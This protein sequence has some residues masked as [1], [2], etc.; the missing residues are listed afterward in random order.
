MGMNRDMDDV[1]LEV[2]ENGQGMTAQP[3]LGVGQSLIRDIAAAIAAATPDDVL[4]NA[5]PTL[6]ALLD[7]VIQ[8]H[9]DELARLL[10]VGGE[11]FG[12]DLVRGG[13]LAAAFRTYSAL[14]SQF[15]LLRLPVLHLPLEDLFAHVGV[16]AAVLELA[17]ACDLEPEFTLSCLELLGAPLAGLVTGMCEEAFWSSFGLDPAELD[18]ELVGL[19]RRLLTLV[20]HLT[21][22]EAAARA[23]WLLVNG[24]LFDKVGVFFRYF[25]RLAWFLRSGPKDLSYRQRLKTIITSQ[26]GNPDY[27][28]RIRAFEALAVLTGQKHRFRGQRRVNLRNQLHD[29][30]L[31]AT[32]VVPLGLFTWS[33]LIPLTVWAV[34]MALDVAVDYVPSLAANEVLGR[35]FFGGLL[36]A[37]VA[38][39]IGLVVGKVVGDPVS[40]SRLFAVFGPA[41]G[42][43]FV[44]WRWRGHVL[45]YSRTELW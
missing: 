45:S 36:G 22:G 19:V 29:T 1:N 43:P 10:G 30:G 39:G 8:A 31:F 35:L 27:S 32:M 20:L 33:W 15:P 42:V 44:A 41:V 11:E 38:A 21:A 26:L 40:V 34:I 18:E 16:D 13:L 6:I 37:S 5:E 17:M 24:Q 4:D 25:A 23:E 28:V 9:A 12:P 2:E 14:R 3:R 7:V